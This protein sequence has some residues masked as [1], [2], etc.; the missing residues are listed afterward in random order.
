MCLI[1]ISPPGTDKTS[2]FFKNACENGMRFNKD[3][4]GLLVYFPNTGSVFVNK[5]INNYD[6]LDSEIEKLNRQYISFNDS[7][8]IVHH[9]LATRG[10]INSTNCHP[11]ITSLP[12]QIDSIYDRT[13]TKFFSPADNVVFTIHNLF[14]D[15]NNRLPDDSSKSDTYIFSRD[16]VLKNY[17]MIMDNPLEFD[18]LYS[19]MY[20]NSKLVIVKPGRD[21]KGGVRLIGQFL[22]EDGYLFSNSGYCLYNDLKSTTVFYNK[23]E[24]K[25]NSNNFP[26]LNSNNNL[27]EKTNIEKNTNSKKM[28]SSELFQMTMPEIYNTRIEK[29]K[30]NKTTNINHLFNTELLN[31]NDNDLQNFLITKINKSYFEFIIDS[32]DLLNDYLGLYIGNNFTCPEEFENIITKNIYFEVQKIDE[33][34]NSYILFPYAYSNLDKYRDSLETEFKIHKQYNKNTHLDCDMILTIKNEYLESYGKIID[35]I[36]DLI[37]S[38][39]NQLKKLK[40]DVKRLIV[41][42]DNVNIRFKDNTYTIAEVREALMQYQ[43]LKIYKANEKDLVK[44]IN[45]RSK[46]VK[47]YLYYM[48]TTNTYNMKEE[49]DFKDFNALY[50]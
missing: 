44:L 20:N 45:E 34:K 12:P 35:L 41:S 21:D 47:T 17:Q 29:L 8:L 4:T 37:I 15:I 3:L 30:E 40:Y 19:K 48:C 14:I 6:D 9:R 42:P 49:E 50:R 2:N 13:I 25:N 31:K 7:W 33:E 18:K 28:Y 5:G 43:W 46:F 16:I 23:H 10:L 11:I 39:K 27:L 1:N 38:S 26:L 32:S 24:Q 22:K 36:D